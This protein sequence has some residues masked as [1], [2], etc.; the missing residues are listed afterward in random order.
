MEIPAKAHVLVIDG[1][2]MLL[3]MN[4]GSAAEP[5]LAPVVQ[6]EQTGPDVV[7]RQSDAPGRSFQSFTHG[8]SAYEQ[9]DF[10]Q[11]D[12]DRFAADASDMLKREVLEGRIEA[13]IVVAAPRTLGELR[14]AWHG[15]V[16]KRVIG[17]VAKVMTSHPTEEIAAAI[18]AA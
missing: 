1:G 14:K 8:R 11:L 18:A 5:S 10:K 7:D 4:E 12:E 2:R 9:T 16:E 6:R 15:E 17:E 3:L 13:L